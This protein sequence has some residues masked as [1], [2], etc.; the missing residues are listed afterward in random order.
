MALE[1]DYGETLVSE[2]EAV[3]QSR[4]NRQ[5]LPVPSRALQVTRHS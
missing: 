4:P 2:E 3:Q 5:S 1:P